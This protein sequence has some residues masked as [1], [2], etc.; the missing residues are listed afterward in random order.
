MPQEVVHESYSK[1]PA[2]NYERYFVP[3]IGAPMARDLIAKAALRPGE[4]VLD[5]AC[6]TGVV[7]RLAAEQVGDTG[8]VAGADINPGMLAVARASV[9]ANSSIKFY[10]TGAEAMPL[11][12]E[13]FDVVLCQMGLQFFSNKPAALRE[14]ARVLTPG[15]RLLLN[16]PGPTPEP[17]STLAGALARH[18]N[19]G[20]ASFV[21]QV[22]SLND[23]G[24]L[25]NL[26]ATAGFADIEVQA[27][28]KTLRLPPPQQF[29]WQYLHSTPL[30]EAIADLD[31]SKRDAL[32]RDVCD[33]WKQLEVGGAMEL[34]VRMTTATGHKP[35]KVTH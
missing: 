26:L 10:D 33:K 32:E 22:F 35:A 34:S 12:D 11:A 31:S 16:V 30:A 25:R 1:R 20:I 3:A 8:T 29:L 27:K 7:T 9:R 13:A 2:E 15:G 17:L 6:G 28:P 5:V 23:A 14:M 4:R 21:H 18:L 24:E 19:P